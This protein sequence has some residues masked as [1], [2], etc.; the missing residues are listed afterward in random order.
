MIWVQVLPE[1]VTDGVN[2]HRH[3][4][5]KVPRFCV[6]Q[7]LESVLLACQHLL[8]G[9]ELRAPTGII[10][11]SGI[12]GVT[13]TGTLTWA[14]MVEFES[15]L[16]AANA[17]QGRLAYMFRAAINKATKTTVKES[18]QA[19]YLQEG[20]V[21]NGYP[22]LVTEQVPAQHLIFGN[23]AELI[24]ALW[25]ALDVFGDPYTLGD[26]GGLV[27]RGFQDA[28]VGVRHAASFS[29]AKGNRARNS[30]SR[31]RG[32][33]YVVPPAPLPL[34]LHPPPRVINTL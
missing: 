2:G 5:D 30:A 19:S 34:L 16:G 8:P 14:L 25:G 31:N 4:K 22:C 11:T 13:T 12:G 6:H 18:G 27:L 29:V 24:L 3:G 28:D 1:P 7:V 26:Q 17:L 15:D 33:P 9:F 23:W 10:N 32:R 21:M 20:G